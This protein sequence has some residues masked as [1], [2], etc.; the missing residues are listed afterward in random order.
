MTSRAASP[1]HTLSMVI[2]VKAVEGTVK[3]KEKMY[4]SGMIAHPYKM[5]INATYPNRSPVIK[6]AYIDY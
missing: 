4:I 6:E 3:K 2:L 5:R 1:V